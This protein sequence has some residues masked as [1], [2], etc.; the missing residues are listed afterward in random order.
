[1][2]AVTRWRTKLPGSSVTWNRMRRRRA[3]VMCSDSRP[4]AQ[5]EPQVAL[6]LFHQRPSNARLR[7]LDPR[8]S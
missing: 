6:P 5:P 1:M 2:R 7:R 8:S 4:P 3:D